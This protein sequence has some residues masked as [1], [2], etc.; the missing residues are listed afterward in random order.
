MNKIKK[1]LSENPEL[2]MHVVEKK[3][4]NGKQLIQF[5]YKNQIVH[6]KQGFIAYVDNQKWLKNRHSVMDEVERYFCE[7]GE[8][9]EKLDFADEIECNDCTENE[10]N[11]FCEKHESDYWEWYE[12]EFPK[13]DLEYGGVSFFDVL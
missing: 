1:F 4:G 9:I 11:Y 7:N 13:I 8:V 10:N 2:T 3:F 12:N 6:F 5:F